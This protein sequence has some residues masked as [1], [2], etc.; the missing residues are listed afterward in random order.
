MNNS[1][2]A[3][4]NL[5]RKLKW[6]RWTNFCFPKKL[7]TRIIYN[8]R[9]GKKLTPLIHIDFVVNKT[10]RFIVTFPYDNKNSDDELVEAFF[11]VYNRTL[12]KIK[13][14]GIIQ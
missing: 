1:R 6:A 12:N 4:K 2:K 8:W 13:L 3:E 10:R 7:N 5:L 11:R 14:E 9:H